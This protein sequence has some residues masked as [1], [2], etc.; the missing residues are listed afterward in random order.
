MT[1]IDVVDSKIKE[2]DTYQQVREKPDEN[3]RAIFD[4]LIVYNSR[5][6]INE[7]NYTMRL[8]DNLHRLGYY[9]EVESLFT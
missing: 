3:R 8:I 7:K 1:K 4:M 9:K 6:Y 2:W 5:M